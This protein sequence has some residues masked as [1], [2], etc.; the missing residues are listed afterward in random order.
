MML[1]KQVKI[2]N[3]LGLHLRAATKLVQLASEFEAEILISCDE[4]TADA[5]SI[6][7]VLMLAAIIGTIVNIKVIGD[8]QE[9]EQKIMEKMVSLINNRFDEGE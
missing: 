4:Q 5:K 3:K 8:N 7:D 6:M 9:E 2:I 1:E